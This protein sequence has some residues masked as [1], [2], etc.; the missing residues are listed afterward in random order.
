MDI[1]QSIVLGIIQGLTE[2][3]PIS[4]SGHLIILPKFFNWADQGLAFDAVMHLATGLAIIFVLHKEI[5][6]ILKGFN[7][8]RQ[9]SQYRINRKL[10]ILIILAII[11]AGVVGLLFNNLIEDKLRTIEVVAWSLIFWGVVLGWAEYYNNKLINKNFLES[12]NW[13][14]SLVVG[15][16]QVI[17]LIPGTSRSGIT[18]TG[19]LFS[20]IDKKTA[21]KFSFLVGLPL[22]LGAGVFKL[23]ELIRMGN[24]SEQS[25]ILF[26]GFISALVSGFLAI[27]LLIWLA[28]RASFQ[29]FVVYRIVLGIALTY[30]PNLSPNL[31]A[32]SLDAITNS[33][34]H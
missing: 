6:Q 32:L 34:T 22:I 5:K 26:F 12:I 24:F 7:L 20:G 8:K 28:D 14:Q 9:D 13:K 10:M 33:S 30:L 19:G 11:P 25:M 21:V 3:L 18:I 16:M 2:F 1:M 15:L 27:K 4:S 29:M 31:Y 17:A 23:V